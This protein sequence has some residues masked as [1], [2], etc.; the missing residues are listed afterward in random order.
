MAYQ[1]GKHEKRRPARQRMGGLILLYTL[2]IAAGLGYAALRWGETVKKL[3]HV[4][5]KLAVK[6]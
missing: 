5:I 4:L 6:A 1:R 2:P 3:I